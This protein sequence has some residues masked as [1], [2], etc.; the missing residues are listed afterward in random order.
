PRLLLPR[1]SLAA[2]DGIDHRL[3]EE[4]GDHDPE[5]HSA[6]G[7]G[8]RADHVMERHGQVIIDGALA[9]VHHLDDQRA[10]IDDDVDQHE[11]AREQDHRARPVRGDMGVETVGGHHVLSLSLVIPGH[12]EAVSPESI[13]TSAPGPWA[14]RAKF[15]KQGRSSFVC[16]ECGKPQARCQYGFRARASGA[17]RNDEDVESSMPQN[18]TLGAAST[19]AR[20]APRSK[21]SRLVKPNMPANSAAGICWMPVLYSCTALLKKRRL[22]AILFSRSDSSFAS[23]WKLALALRSG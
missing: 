23:C 18:F 10:G 21:K 14:I 4:I 12:R 16:R 9:V 1:H 15:K 8:Q 22:A 11:Q 13:A 7:I 20:L 19:S 17:P 5:Q 3:V 6:R 2:G